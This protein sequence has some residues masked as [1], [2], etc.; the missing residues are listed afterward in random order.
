VEKRGDED[1]KKKIEK[2]I[3]NFFLRANLVNAPDNKMQRR[4]RSRSVHFLGTCSQIT[5]AQNS[6]VAL[7]EA[8]C[9]NVNLSFRS[10]DFLLGSNRRPPGSG[11][12]ISCS[13]QLS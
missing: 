11:Q 2:K 8:L 4:L 7:L 6:L 5:V 9:S 10:L 12:T 1:A 3:K 13:D